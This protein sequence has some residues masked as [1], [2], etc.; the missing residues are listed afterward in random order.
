M[1]ARADL[2]IDQLEDVSLAVDEAVE[3]VLTVFT[4]RR[5]AS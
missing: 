3:R 5:G 2:P 1:S 4:D